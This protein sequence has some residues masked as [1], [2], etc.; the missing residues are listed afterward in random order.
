MCVFNAQDHSASFL[1]K[2]EIT[3]SLSLFP[4][5]YH[6]PGGSNKTR[7]WHGAGTSQIVK[8]VI[9]V[10]G[11]RPACP[12]YVLTRPPDF[13]NLL[14][15]VLISCAKI[16][17]LT[18]E[19]FGVS[20]VWCQAVLRGFLLGAA[21][22]FASV[23]M[24]LA[25]FPTV[26]SFL[27]PIVERVINLGGVGCSDAP[28]NPSMFLVAL[29]CFCTEEIISL[30][31]SLITGAVLVSMPVSPGSVGETLKSTGSTKFCAAP[32]GAPTLL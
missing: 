4:G 2:W 17:H 18:L 22:S 15:F 12:L 28:A 6:Q 5:K 29:F 20:M 30:K 7:W 21:G 32:S 8:P 13:F 27:L 14:L 24:D 1:L 16:L 31:L 3:P 11:K 9:Y 10:V 19:Q 23:P 26:S 25:L